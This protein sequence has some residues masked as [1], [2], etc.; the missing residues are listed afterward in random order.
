MTTKDDERKT[1]LLTLK[2]ISR[3][4]FVARGANPHARITFVKSADEVVNPAVKADP[5]GKETVMTALQQLEARA[6]D[7]RKTD[8]SLTQEGAFSK[9]MDEHP[10]LVEGY[11][12]NE[13]GTEPEAVEK[14]EPEPT[15][16]EKADA[17]V[18]AIAKSHGEGSAE[19][20]KAM[21]TR[22]E[23]LGHE[24]QAEDWRAQAAFIG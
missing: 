23:L 13:F 21:A 14:T 22:C 5:E 4:A 8:N 2:R 16:I 18:V 9:A 10:D 3:V 15:Q 19:F 11:Y 12:D 24:D 6:A 7:I 17:D 20:A 1:G